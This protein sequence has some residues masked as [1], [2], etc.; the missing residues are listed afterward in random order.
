MQL[1]P[2]KLTILS[3]NLQNYTHDP[4]QNFRRSMTKPRAEM[5]AAFVAATMIAHGADTLLVMETG[6]DAALAL[7]KIA[8]YRTKFGG[9]DSDP[10]ITDLT[11]GTPK[12]ADRHRISNSINAMKRGCGDAA[13]HAS[14]VMGPQ[15]T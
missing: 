13:A 9:P 8:C 5:T 14:T 7:Q 4:R 12:L 3:W 15:K 6:S 10:F 2:N 11:H 1:P